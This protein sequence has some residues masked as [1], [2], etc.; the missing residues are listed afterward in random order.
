MYCY[1]FILFRL[2]ELL[3]KSLGAL[4]KLTFKQWLCDLEFLIKTKV[5]NF[6]QTFFTLMNFEQIRVFWIK[7]NTLAAHKRTD[8]LL[9]FFRLFMLLQTLFDIFISWKF[10]DMTVSRDCLCFGFQK[11]TYLS[12]N[13]EGWSLKL[14]QK[15]I[16]NF[17]I[18]RFFSIFS[19]TIIW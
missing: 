18:F 1:C 17:N 12:K 16:Y 7:F 9:Y 2:L 10:N 14:I 15:M 11:Y 13:T 19:F 6:Y 4:Q 8:L 3:L 5:T